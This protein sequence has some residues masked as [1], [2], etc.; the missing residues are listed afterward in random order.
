MNSLPNNWKYV[1]LG[2]IASQGQ[3]GW[4]SKASS[5][6]A[7]KYV[8]TTDITSGRINWETVPYCLDVPSDA[9]KYLLRDGDILISR[10]GSVGYSMLLKNVT[11]TAVFA[12]YLIR[13]RASDS[14]HAPYL[15]YFLKSPAYWTQISE[16]AAGIALANV[17]AKKLAAIK[18]PLP[19]LAEQ[20]RIADKLDVLLRRVD[21]CRARLARVPAI[22]KRFRQAVLAAATSGRL[23]EEWREGNP[24]LASTSELSMLLQERNGIDIFTR[25]DTNSRTVT[26]V[27]LPAGWLTV[28]VHAT[29]EVFLG[30]QRSPEN[31][32]G[33]NM[34]PYVRAANVTWQ[35]WDLSDVKEMNF[36][37][38][39]F[40]RYRLRVGDILLGEGSGSAD[41]VGKPAIWRGEIPDC[42][43]QNTLICVRPHFDD[44][45]YLHLAFLYAALSK[46][47]VSGARGV[48]IHHIGKD[49]FSAHLIPFPAL[50]EQREIVRRVETL[51]AYA[52]RLE[53]RYAAAREQVEQL[54]PSLLAKAFRGEMV[55]QQPGEQ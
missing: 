19:P 16:A 55:P 40:A 17:N 33:P 38:R 26:A 39:D 15:A 52:D 4:T 22:L 2:E 21:A 23:S 24:E 9:G 37:A 30:R 41:E 20:Q 31:H 53:A 47:F 18:I 3:Y 54:T 50:A 51:F 46:A 7:I 1:T 35:G 12:S 29:G 43:F 5:Q 48:N 6:G 27:E 11:N 8:R 45:Q 25:K 36:D 32:S 28:P 42:C 44:S 49:R 13:F 34:R 14:V 10:A